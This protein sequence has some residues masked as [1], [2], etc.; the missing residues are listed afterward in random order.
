MI[1]E[2]AMLAAV[3]ISIWTAV[4]T[5]ARSAVRWLMNMALPKERGATT[6]N[7]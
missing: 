4:S 7:C 2:R 6:K 5:I 1:T 3:H